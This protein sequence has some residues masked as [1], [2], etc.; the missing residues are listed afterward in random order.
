LIRKQKY[1]S[2]SDFK[3]FL[4]KLIHWLYAHDHFSFFN[5]NDYEVEYEP[6]KIFAAAGAL[7]QCVPDGEDPFGELRSFFESEKDWLIGRLNY[8]LKNKIEN[9]SSRNPDML[10]SEDMAFFI[11][12]TQVLTF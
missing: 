12:E 4:P 7:K 8:D 5:G 11:P 9:L 2:I 1:F 10:L 6:F 3:E